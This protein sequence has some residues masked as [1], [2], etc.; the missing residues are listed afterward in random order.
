MPNPSTQVLIWSKKQQCYHLKTRGHLQR[1]FRHADASAWLAWLA[2]QTTFAFQGQAGHLSVIKEARRGGA[3]YWYAYRSQARHTRKRYLGKTSTL[4]LERLEQVAGELSGAHVPEP[5]APHSTA[6]ASRAQM[7]AGLSDAARK[8]EQPL[9]LLATKLATPRVGDG[10]VV[11]ERLLLLLDG[12]LAHRLTLLSAA[13]GWGK[14]TLLATW[15]AA[16][17]EGRG[18][19]TESVGSSLSP[20]SSALSTRLAWLSLDELDNDLTRF[21]IALIAAL[22]TCLPDAGA[23]ALAMLQ[24]PE[25]APLSAILTVLLNQLAATPAAAPML[26]IL[27]DYHLIN[28]Q[29]IHESVSFFLEHLPDHLHLV[30]A[31]RVDPDLP[32]SRWRV[33]GELLEIRAADLR[34]TQAE[35]SSFF[36]AAL[37]AGLAEA[38]VRLLSARTEGWIAGMQLAALAMRQRA[39]RSA[40]VQSFTGSHHYLLD[41]IQEEILE[42]QELAVQRFL[43]QSAVLRRL[44]AALCTALTGDAT[45]QAMLERLE[46]NNLFVVPLDDQRQWYGMHELFREVLLARLQ[47]SEPELVPLLHQRAAHYFAAQDEMREAI[48]HAL[49]ARDFSY[50]ASLIERT[51]ERLWLSGEA[52]TVQIWIGALPDDVVRQHARLALTAALR[53]LESLHS[54]VREAYARAQAQVEQTIARLEVVLQRQQE[55]TA[56]PDIDE[57][58]LALPD[59][60]VALLQRRIHL[61]RALIVARA[62]LIRGD[63]TRMRLLAEETEAL[64]VQEEV[65]WKLIALWITFWYIEVIQREGALLIGRLLEAKQQ[66]IAAGDQVATRRVMRWLAFAYWRAGRLRLAEQE[67]LEGLALVEQIGQHSAATRYVHLVEQLDEHSASTG[68]FH[69]HL[70]CV[71]YAWNRLEAAALSVQQL[72]RIAQTRQQADLLIMGNTYLVWHLLASGDLV[73]AKQ[74]LQQAEELAQQEQFATHTGSVV[75]ARAR[76]WLAA[77]DLDAANR[78]AEQM[79]FSPEIWDPNCKSE[80]LMHIRVYLAQQQYTQALAALERFSSQLDRPGDIQ[81]TI[82]FLALHAVALHQAGQNEQARAVAVRLLALTEPEGNIRV[83]LDL[84]EP[85][86]QVLQSLLD[87]RRDQESNLAAAS[88]AFVQKLLAAFPRTEEKGLRSE[89][90]IPEHSVLSPQSSALVEP[91]TRREQEILHLLIAGASN[92]EIADTLVISLATVKKHVSNLLGKLGVTSRSQAIARA[93]DWPHLA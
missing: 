64:A 46:R 19:R 82:G 29:A 6:P 61:L 69:Y 16:R 90:H 31:S 56:S 43:L 32:L 50:A 71:Y 30:L 81:T 67:C 38:D 12:A 92:Q 70:A 60:E 54:T 80:F 86:K 35:A 65:R 39:D 20:Q 88:A 15:L 9:L 91:L 68:Y 72:L 47:A 79:V 26:L 10:L 18:L 21:W 74:A 5:R 27:D 59:A 41:Y 87:P 23:L 17:T 24:S 2:E 83:Y 76:Y 33:R 62:S 52:Q 8:A 22:R 89:Y 93:R 45:S 11:R 53:L 7:S 44:N 77:G 66:V 84:A 13:A 75:A 73:A 28:D 51:A 3:S 1:S 34:F 55:A 63:A 42:R 37:G 36:K 4:T 48:T 58:L 14:T 78:W 49:A 85:M 57:T 25:R 40:F